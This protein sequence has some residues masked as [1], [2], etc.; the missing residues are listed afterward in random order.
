MRLYTFAA[1]HYAEKARWALDYKKLDYE[2]VVLAPGPHQLTL[3]K[4]APKTHVPVLVHDGEVVQGS[5]QILDHLDERFPERPLTPTDPDAAAE[6]RELER[7]L[8]DDLGVRVR[9]HFYVYMLRERRLLSRLFSY[10]GPWW[11]PAFYGLTFPVVRR[12]IGSSYDIFGETVPDQ[13][14]ALRELLMDVG[15]RVEGREHL[16]SDRFT[17]VDLALAA[18]VG[19]M[20]FPPKH[21][22]SWSA[23]QA[24]PEGY[25]SFYASFEGTPLHQYVMRTYE[26]YR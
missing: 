12:A 25:R 4:I 18:I 24:W 6:C 21:P 19:W 10:R 13:E 5:A 16:L 22:M 26:V 9:R 23:T 20:W 17:R 3:R 7:R 11:A 8:D 1:S 2:E 14:R 15:E